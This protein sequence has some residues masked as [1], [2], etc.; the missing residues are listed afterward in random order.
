MIATARRVLLIALLPAVVLLAAPTSSSARQPAPQAPEGRGF[1][2]ARVQ[3]VLPA[4]TLVIVV[5]PGGPGER[6]GLKAGDVILEAG[7]KMVPDEKAL[8]DQVLAATRPG[9]TVRFT[10]DR[11][12]RQFELDVVL[13]PAAPVDPAEIRE[14]VLRHCTFSECPAC[15]G[16]LATLDNPA[17][18][19]CKACRIARAQTIAGCVRDGEQAG[20]AQPAATQPAAARTTDPPATSLALHEV[21]LDPARVGPGE[22]FLINVSYSSPSNAPVSFTF[23]ISAGGRELFASKT[24][25]IAGTSGSRTLYTRSVAAA[26]EPGAYQVRVTLSLG[27]QGAFRDV[28]LTVGAK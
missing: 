1:I 6:G 26:R 17:S 21:T 28:T 22:K 9:Q 13:G 15:I 23:A 27:G 4:G 25:D 3:G 5:S 8:L 2:G 12:G 20:A 14:T 11:Q 16:D 18:A 24:E 19:E 10:V 7:G